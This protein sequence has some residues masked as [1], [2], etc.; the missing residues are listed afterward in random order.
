MKIYQVIIEERHAGTRTIL[1]AKENDAIK[2][3]KDKAE[4]LST[5]HDYRPI[6]ME[7][8]YWSYYAVCSKSGDTVRVIGKDLN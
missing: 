2:C 7:I 8:A 5:L 1:F 4:Y 3:A 6:E